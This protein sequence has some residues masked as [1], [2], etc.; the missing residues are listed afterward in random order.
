MTPSLVVSIHDVAPA[1]ATA[2]R[3]WAE[4][5]DPLGIPLTFLVV[6]GPWQGMTFGDPGDDGTDLAAWL[7]GRAARGDEI[8][9]HGWCHRADVPGS[10]P[11][12]LVGA[13]VARG[14]AEFW[15]LDRRT[16]RERTRAGLGVLRAHGLSPEGTTPP[17]WLASA[18]AVVGF[19]E[20]G[21]SYATD[22]AGVVDLRTGRRWLAPALCHRPGP[23]GSPRTSL[24]EALG[25][26]VL[27][28]AATLVRAGRSV[29]VGLHPNDLP[30]PG[31]AEAAVR[32]IGRCRDLGAEPL[33]YLDVI[34]RD[35]GTRRAG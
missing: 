20:A 4:L 6:P 10:L 25:R 11:R 27:G 16:A 24:G 1:T 26:Q 5:L 12:R 13:A 19:A 23:A 35:L 3:R 8:A 7:R 29:R 21:L 14:A 2:S 30:R 33:T 22:H 28:G 9:L 34:G 15:A 18:A 31:L 32:T 17:G